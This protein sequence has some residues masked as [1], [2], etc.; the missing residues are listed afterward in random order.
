MG[1]P[2]KLQVGRLLLWFD[3]IWILLNG[4][5]KVRMFGILSDKVSV[6][7]HWNG[8]VFVDLI[9][10]RQ[11]WSGCTWCIAH[12]SLFDIILAY[13]EQKCLGM[14]IFA[15]HWWWWQGLSKRLQYVVD[16]VFIDRDF[17]YKAM[18][19]FIQ[20][21]WFC[22]YSVVSDFMSNANM[23]LCKTLCDPIV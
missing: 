18:M 16:I 8:S 7:R 12:I 1:T 19:S 4:I 13:S 22:C 2:V 9:I 6:K 5:F 3:L 20:R 10:R 17:H 14:F 23:N 21:H 11:C 15:M